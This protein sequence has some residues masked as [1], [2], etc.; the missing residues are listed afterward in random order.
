MS[1][2]I[3]PGELFSVDSSAIRSTQGVFSRY[4]AIMIFQHYNAVF[5]H[6]R[7][8]KRFI[9]NNITWGLF[10]KPNLCLLVLL[11][12][13]F[14]RNGGFEFQILKSRYI[15][16]S[17]CG[18]RLVLGALTYMSSTGMCR[19]KD[20]PFLTDPCLRHP[21]LFSSLTRA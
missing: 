21:P 20:P 2:S 11:Y 17:L 12:S 15:C 19:G 16:I 7:Q 5:L 9:W 8:T 6:S 3:L 18:F 14:S 4:L 13:G 10:F 1:T